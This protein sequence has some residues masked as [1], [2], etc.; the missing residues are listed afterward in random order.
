MKLFHESNQVNLN[1]IQLH[2]SK[3]GYQFDFHANKW[4]LD[5]SYVINFSRLRRINKETEIGFRKALCRYAEELSS[6]FTI[7]VFT[8]FNMYFDATCCE[9][10]NII[11]LTNYR[12]SLNADNEHKLGVLKGFLIAWHEW[13]FKG[14]DAEVVR[15]LNELTLKGC[16]KGKA[17]LGACPYS[18]PLSMNELGGLF[19][20]AANAFAINKINLEEFAYFMV[21]ALT[22]RRPIQIRYLRSRDLV[23]RE[24]SNGYDFVINCPRSKQRNSKFREH[25]SI[26]PINEDLYL[27]LQN[28][29]DYS[30]KLIEDKLNLKLSNNLLKEIPVFLELKRVKKIRSIKDLENKLKNTPDFLHMTSSRARAMLHK[31]SCLNTARSERTGEYINF[32]AYRFR[33][34]KG[35]NLARRGIS[36]VALAV[37]LDHSDTQ[38]IGI[39]VE[40]TEETVMQIDEI[41]APILAPLAQAFSGKLIPSERDAVRANDPNSRIKNGSSNSL[42][43]CGTYAFCA[44]G[45][46]ACYTC[47]NFQPWLQANHKEVLDEIMTE[48]K[49]QVEIGIS[50]NVIESTDRLLLAVQQVIIM[51]K[52]KNL[53]EILIDG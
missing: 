1:S 47:S 17:V 34:T 23:S 33:Y 35:T 10:I 18:G 38:S 16:R 29:R 2:K 48:R 5:G 52:S 43:N 32:N 4:M 51:C 22:G 12:A 21:L 53:E 37:A 15:Y 36:G 3:S 7:T 6:A 46:R 28:Q 24:D 9:S 30:I 8:H 42:G 13:G 45:Y 14:V 19:D 25:F 27:I 41:M 11:D 39:Y 50:P 40:N 49:Y 20:W 26:L 31:L 44:S